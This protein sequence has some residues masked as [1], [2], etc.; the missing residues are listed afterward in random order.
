MSIKV[1][2][3][4]NLGKIEF[5]RASLEKLL[6]E[7]YREGYADG[8]KHTKDN[9]WTWAPSLTTTNLPIT[10]LNGTGTTTT[11]TSPLNLTYANNEDNKDI[12]SVTI[13][14]ETVPS[15]PTN[16]AKVTATLNGEPVD[17]S[18]VKGLLEKVQEHFNKTMNSSNHS[19][20]A[21]DTLAKEIRGY[22]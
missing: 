7:T 10:Y 18:D 19:S 3:T 4:N 22:F 17:M 8:E 6:N 11:D 13:T 16:S 15:I 2:A 12:S 1:F 5:D 9:Y 21:F 14:S 20:N